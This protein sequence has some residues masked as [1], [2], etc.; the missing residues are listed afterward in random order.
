MSGQFSKKFIAA[1]E[2]QFSNISE[3]DNQIAKVVKT[4]LGGA[5]QMIDSAAE[6]YQEEIRSF[7]EENEE[8]KNKVDVLNDQVTNFKSLAVTS[9][10][11]SVKGNVMVSTDKSM[12]EVSEFIIDTIAKSGAPRPS[13]AAL[14][15]QQMN[16]DSKKTPESLISPSVSQ[17]KDNAT[18]PKAKNTKTKT[19]TG[20]AAATAS[21]AVATASAAVA[22][23][24]PIEETSKANSLGNLFKVHLGPRLK[25]LLFKGL[26]ASVSA[27]SATSPEFSVSHDVPRYLSGQMKLLEKAAYSIRKSHKGTRTKINLK[28]RNLHLCVKSASDQDWIPAAQV[29]NM[30]NTKVEYRANETSTYQDVGELINSLEKY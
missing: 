13:P 25:N 29:P 15:I 18:S 10:L 1:L 6:E 21:A 4:L 19:K 7:K 24:A 30:M 2:A 12:A 3:E 8:L 5:L 14:Y 11:E 17:K 27:K 28:D 22:T 26:A 16:S 20:K 9:Q 23:A